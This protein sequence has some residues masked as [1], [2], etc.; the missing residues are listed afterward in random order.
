[1]LRWAGSATGDFFPLSSP[2]LVR[3]APEPQ[4]TTTPQDLSA[5]H[6][7]PPHPAIDGPCR[8]R[9][10]AFCPHHPLRLHCLR[11]EVHDLLL[12]TSSSVHRHARFFIKPRSSLC[13]TEAGRPSESSSRRV[14]FGL[15]QRV[16]PRVQ[17][18]PLSLVFSGALH[19]PCPPKCVPLVSRRRRRRRIAVPV[20]IRMPRGR[21]VRTGSSRGC[22]RPT[23]GT[24]HPHGPTRGSGSIVASGP[25]A[26]GR[27]QRSTRCAASSL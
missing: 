19:R 21:S 5:E 20:C 17:R 22:G 13:P 9:V 4:R 16:R 2:R 15:Q 24:A 12:T 8:S 26:G 23:T 7:A 27:E 14:D 10:G 18:R 1:M 25:P 3:G 11:T 6:R